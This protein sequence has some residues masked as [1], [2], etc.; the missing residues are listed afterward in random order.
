[1]VYLEGIYVDPEVRGS[2]VGRRCLTRITSDLLQTN[3]FDM[4]SC[5]RR[6]PTG[7]CIL[8]NVRFQVDQQLRHDLSKRRNNRFSN[9]IRFGPEHDRK[10]DGTPF[11]FQNPRPVSNECL[12]ANKDLKISH[13][14][15]KKAR[16]GAFDVRIGFSLGLSP[17][18]ILSGRVRFRIRLFCVISR[19]S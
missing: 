11:C 3:S 4:C 16:D 17:N 1:M 7:T 13:R 19:S 5:K 9:V 14:S 12:P 2:G 6:Q 8:P 10:K 15:S 18:S